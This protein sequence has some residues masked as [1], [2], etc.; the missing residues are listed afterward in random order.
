MSFREY[1][2]TAAII[3]GIGALVELSYELISLLF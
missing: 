3:Y 2:E 1:I